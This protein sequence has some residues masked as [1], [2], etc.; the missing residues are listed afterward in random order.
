MVL[1]TFTLPLDW[2]RYNQPVPKS[3][4]I[5]QRDK[6]QRENPANAV[7]ENKLVISSW[8]KHTSSPFMERKTT[9]YY[10]LPQL[11][12]FLPKLGPRVLVVQLQH[13]RN[14][15]DKLLEKGWTA[16]FLGY[17]TGAIFQSSNYC[18]TRCSG[19]FTQVRFSCVIFEELVMVQTTIQESRK[20]IIHMR[21]KGVQRGW[22][23]NKFS[24]IHKQV[25]YISGS[26][27]ILTILW[28]DRKWWQT[29]KAVYLIDIGFIAIT[30]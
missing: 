23:P 2:Q 7:S 4:F 16:V 15:N 22:Q 17:R 19:S 24:Q 6:A 11:L 5:S 21:Q 3:P 29:P 13:Q 18:K 10:C 20:K 28:Y 8:G 26:T 27:A 25:S 12:T 14:P 30:F 1:R 9:H